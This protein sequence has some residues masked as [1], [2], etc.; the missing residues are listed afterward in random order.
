MHGNYYGTLKSTIEDFWRNGKHVLLDIDVQGADS[1]RKL[2]QERCFTVFISPPD[3]N[4]LEQRLRGRGTD[5]EENISKRMKNASEE[6]KRADEF[7]LV[8]VNDDL[9][10]AYS[11]LLNAVNDKMKKWAESN[12]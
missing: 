1:L 3:L 11:K 10:E 12:V 7:D 2:Y 6:M 8:L 9:K 5:S 4:V